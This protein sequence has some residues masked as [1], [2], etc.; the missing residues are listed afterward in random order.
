MR[1][2]IEHLARCL[3]ISSWEKCQMV[4]LTTAL[5]FSYHQSGDPSQAGDARKFTVL[6]GF[7]SDAKR[8]EEFDLKWRARL[9][10][11]DLTYFQMHAFAQSVGPFK[12]WR[13]QENRR[14][15]LLADLLEIIVEHA[16]RKFG[17]VVPVEGLD[18]LKLDP[19]KKHHSVAV[20]VSSVVGMVEEWKQREKYHR[21]PRYVF[22]QGDEGKAV[23]MDTVKNITGLDPSFEHKRDIP[24][25]GIVAFTPL[26]AADLFA[27]ELKKLADRLGESTPVTLS[28]MRFRIPYEVLNK[29]Q[30]DALLVTSG[31][32]AELRTM[33]S[34]DKYFKDN[35]LPEEEADN[36][37]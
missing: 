31:L 13:E 29:K 36:G 28:E 33:L 7:V 18:A 25:K 15:V 2:A 32:G 16:Y 17:V 1:T 14:Q 8:W 34:V 12:G 26:Q 3:A 21:A 24:E 23:I 4:M 22:E 20:A 37:Q 10:E 5:D 27:Y 19:G 6:A 9:S 35:P 30:Q 11:D